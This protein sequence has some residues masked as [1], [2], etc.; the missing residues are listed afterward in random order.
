MKKI[1]TLLILAGVLYGC[2]KSSDED[3]YY[4]VTGIVLDFHTKVP[5]AG[6]KV[7]EQA[8]CTV[9]CFPTDSAITDIA[10]MVSF[11][12]KKDGIHIPLRSTKSNYLSLAPRNLFS[13][14][15]ISRTDTMYLSRPS[16]I[17]V[18]AHKTITYLPSDS[19]SIQVLGDYDY[20]YHGSNYIYK[21]IYRDKANMP[22]KIFNLQAVYAATQYPYYL[23]SLKLYF[24]KEI[25]RNGAVFSSQTDSTNIIQFGT[26]NFTLNY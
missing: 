23:G 24:M 8:F 15:D 26:Q 17:N 12:H 9:N 5:V 16:F 7:Y 25:I 3:D 11:R 20:S 1:I 21:T 13:G 18:T 10:G 6:A 2:K 19:V 14:F 22:D 4:T